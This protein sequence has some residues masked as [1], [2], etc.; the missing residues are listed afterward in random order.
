MSNAYC[1]EFMVLSHFQDFLSPLVIESVIP[2]S[3]QSKYRIS[4][5]SCESQV[6]HRHQ[7]NP[8]LLLCGSSYGMC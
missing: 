5:S 6:R 4:T 7:G 2:N 8:K 3:E 1:S